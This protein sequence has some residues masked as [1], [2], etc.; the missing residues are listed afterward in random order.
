MNENRK[1]T[2]TVL[3]QAIKIPG[4]K[5]IPI[6]GKL[7]TTWNRKDALVELSFILL[8]SSVM[9]T[10]KFKCRRLRGYGHLQKIGR[11]WTS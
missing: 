11:L 10:R 1:K 4:I 5:I 8:D 2:V 9:S 3:L 6:D 7:T